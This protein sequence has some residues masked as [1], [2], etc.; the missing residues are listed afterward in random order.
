MALVNTVTI[1][2][3]SLHSDM[4]SLKESDSVHNNQLAFSLLEE[5]LGIPPIISASDMA[6]KEQIDKLSMV[7]YLTQIHDAFNER[8][9]TRGKHQGNGCQTC[10]VQ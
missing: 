3:L 4:S 1:P 6:T 7:L 9:P 2:H 8:T 5:E 10:Y